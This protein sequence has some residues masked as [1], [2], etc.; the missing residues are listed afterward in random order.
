[1]TRNTDLAWVDFLDRLTDP[2][3]DG[4]LRRFGLGLTA[5]VISL[6]YGVSWL[7]FPPALVTMPLPRRFGIGQHVAVST[8]VHVPC[9]IGLAFAFLA[10]Y[11]HFH[12][13]WG[14]HSRL[15]AYYEP[16]QL[17]AL[18]GLAASV[19]YGVAA[20]AFTT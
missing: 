16:L 6:V 9:A 8:S 10:L 1:M 14:N 4:P 2:P 19:L 17:G 13:Y 5:A 20:F 3:S 11:L 18:V 15:N 12:W 7:L